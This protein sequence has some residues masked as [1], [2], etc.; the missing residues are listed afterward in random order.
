[1]VV[2]V[3]VGDLMA[4]TAVTMNITVFSDVGPCRLEDGGSRFPRNVGNVLP[5]YTAF[6]SRRQK[7]I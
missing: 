4:L 2:I 5:D 1:M 6:L 3:F 7:R